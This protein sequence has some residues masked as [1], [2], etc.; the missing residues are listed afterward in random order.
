MERKTNPTSQLYL[1]RQIYYTRKGT[2]C[3][4]LA[5]VIT[6]TVIVGYGFAAWNLFL[7]CGVL[8]AVARL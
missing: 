4:V 6:Q 5:L 2:L 1:T 3:Q 7:P 8:K